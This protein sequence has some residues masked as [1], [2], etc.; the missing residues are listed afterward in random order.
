MR[1]PLETGTGTQGHSLQASTIRRHLGP[2]R[3]LF[4]G[5]GATNPDKLRAGG[6]RVIEDD[7]YMNACLS[8]NARA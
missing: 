5:K 7:P 3:D 2:A 8:S 6:N 4:P 1:G